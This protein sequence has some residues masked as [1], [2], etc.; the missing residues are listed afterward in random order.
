[1]RH[2]IEKTQKGFRLSLNK[3][4]YTEK[5]LKKA[6]Q[7]DDSGIRKMFSDEKYICLEFKTNKIIELLKWS[8]YLAYL[9]RSS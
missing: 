3:N 8:N 6:L 4:I 7:A 9:L 2:L 1:M 5:L